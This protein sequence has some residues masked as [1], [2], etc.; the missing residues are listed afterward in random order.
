MDSADE[1][2]RI[3]PDADMPPGQN[4]VLIEIDEQPRWL[5][6]DGVPLPDLIAEL[7]VVTTHLVRHGLWVPQRDDTL[8]P[9]MRF[10]S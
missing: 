2:Y 10:A 3:V 7:N 1:I 8:P 6:R 9:R 5:I 4:V